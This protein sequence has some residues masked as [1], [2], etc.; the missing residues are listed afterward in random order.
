MRLA[1]LV[2]VVAVLAA[3]AAHASP[4]DRASGA[5]A[6]AAAPTIEALA[7]ARHVL[8]GLRPGAGLGRAGGVLVAPGLNVWRLPGRVAARVVPHLRRSGR[9]VAA[10]PDRVADPATHISR[11]D[12]LLP[13]EWWFGAVGADRVEPP[14]AGIPV[15]VLDT[16]LDFGHPEFAGRP[17]TVA[18]NR[19]QIIPD[20]DDAHGTAVS[21]VVGAPANGVGLVGIY[22]TAALWEWDFHLARLSSVLTALDA[23]SRRGRSVINISGGFFGGSELLTTA[24]NRA[25][26]RGSIV[27]AAVGNERELG[28]RNFF[29][30]SLPH[31]VTV[32]ATNARSEPTW[33][34][35]RSSALD[36]AAP[37]ERIP[38]AV[39]TAYDPAG[40]DVVSGT[41]FAAPLVAGAVAWV[42]TA[43]PRLGKTQIADVIRASARD[44]GSFGWDRDTGWGIL[45][46]PA[47][48]AAPPPPRDPHEPN[49]DVDAV[50]PGAISR[51]GA[52]PLTGQ[53]LKRTTLSA[54]MDFT[55]DPEDVYRAWV[56]R[57]RRLVVSV[58]G[59]ANVDV[60][61]WGPRTQ[62]VFERGAALRRD[63]LASSARPGTRIDAVTVRNGSGR[64]AFYYVDVFLGRRTA[65]ASYTLTAELVGAQPQPRNVRRGLR[66]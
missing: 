40:F 21:S 45:D 43:R 49:E 47:A 17:R 9:L 32:G 57:G 56:P 14:R 1:G 15:A 2:A 11:G 35:S 60:A 46:L 39:P 34:S 54:R 30:A 64:G 28:N 55:E 52:T 7:Q 20:E 59:R 66:G 29:P 65:N 38:V 19:Q 33:F 24:V 44:V 58:Q 62:S 4:F 41:S 37:G 26:A 50:K 42:W 12:P 5:P 31:V 13:D 3:P 61:I 48:L 53:R 27:V 16:G 23:V 36:V 8:V 25:F 51:R 22:P 10:E 63:L 6:R 18:L